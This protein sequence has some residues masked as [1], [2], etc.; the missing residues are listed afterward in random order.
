MRTDKRIAQIIL[1]VLCLLSIIATIT[2][3]IRYFRQRQQELETIKV[4]AQQETRAAAS[5]IGQLVEMLATIVNKLVQELSNKELSANEIIALLSQKP[6]TISGIG[7]SFAPHTLSSPT[8]RYA[9]YC[10][11]K[12][13]KQEIVQLELQ[14]DYTKPEHQWY[15][16]PLTKGAQFLDDKLWTLSEHILIGFATPFYKHNS[17]KKQ[18]PD[19][20]VFAHQTVEHIKHILTTIYLGK[21]GYWFVLSQDSTLLIHPYDKHGTEHNKLLK[22]MKK[23]QKI[24]HQTLLQQIKAH[25]SNMI[26]YRNEIDG[27]LSWMFIEPIPS[28]PLLLCRVFPHGELPLDR[29]THRQTIILLSL[30]LLAFLIFLTLFLATLLQITPSTLWIVS[31]I[32]ST[33][34]LLELISLWYII[35]YMPPYKKNLV[36]I[37]DKV[38]LYTFLDKISHKH[39]THNKKRLQQKTA[40]TMEAVSAAIRHEPT[41]SKNI[42]HILQYR[43]KQDGYIPTGIYIQHLK[44]ITESQIEMTAY[45]WQRYFDDIHDNVSRGFVLPQAAITK[46]DKVYHSKEQNTETIIWQVRATINQRILYVKY[47]F[48]IKDIQIQI[49]HKDFNQHVTLV[50]DLVSY[51]LI[52][53]TALPGLSKEIHLPG[54]HIANSYFGYKITDYD[55]AFGL[56][57]YGTLGV[58]KQFEKCNQP[59]LCYNITV[60]RFLVNTLISNLLPLAIIALILFVILLTS[61]AQGFAFLGACASVFFGALIAQSRFRGNIE[62]YRLIYFETFYLVMYA[63]LLIV[64]LTSLLHILKVNSLIIRYKK[65]LITKLLYWPIILVTLLIITFRYFY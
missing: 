33:L 31:F 34:L 11:E 27:K 58:Y 7:I 56:Y 30:L 9:P 38:S 21:T 12:D 3:S 52:H 64:I 26:N 36:Q 4:E 15:H 59:E 42:Q 19:G 40:R 25:K 23:Q 20:I 48:D 6:I 62:T 43:Y 63:A 32:I 14:L 37:N 54:W 1:T 45:I 49:V 29:N 55:A 10:I 47:P 5:K 17:T 35:W 22:I 61:E 41:L 39:T 18:L 2:L 60:Q 13:D 57:S 24:D 8:Q 51:K 50:P 28:T 65:N 46:I 44:F 53:P 16:V